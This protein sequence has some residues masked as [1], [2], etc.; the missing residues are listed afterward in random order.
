[1]RALLDVNVLIAL[2]DQDHTLHARARGWFEAN[3][4]TGWAS[5]PLTQNGCVRVMA[6]PAYPNALPVAQ[7]VARLREAIADAHHEFWP[8]DVSLLDERVADATRIHGSRQ[9]TDLYLLALA[10]RRDGTFVTFDTSVVRDA[11]RG[12][13]AGNLTV[14]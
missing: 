7:I 2:L 9:I 14:L 13:T 8:D 3:A 1:M 6:N 5:C 10:V 12:A 11:V 4:R